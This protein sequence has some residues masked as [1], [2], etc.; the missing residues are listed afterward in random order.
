LAEL[1]WLISSALATA[2]TSRIVRGNARDAARLTLTTCRYAV[3]VTA[4]GA[5]VLV[6]GGAFT[7][8]LI[9]GSSFSDARG[10]LAIL[11]VGMVAYSPGSTLAAHLSLR[12]GRARYSIGSAG[13]SAVTTALA[14][15]ALIPVL[16][17]AGAAI[18]C[19]LGYVIGISLAIIWFCRLTQSSPL[20]LIPQPSDLRAYVDL[21]KSLRPS[22]TR[23]RAT[24]RDL[25]G[26]E[27]L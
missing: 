19:D 6:V 8:P 7:I 3:G 21:A 18:A 14:A 27:P 11:A 16:G 23:A 17:A 2:A 25:G 9:F 10:L 22:G 24:E 5:V 1:L 15:F 26:V 20:R 13:S 4:V 12:L